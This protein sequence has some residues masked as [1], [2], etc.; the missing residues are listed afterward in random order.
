MLFKI[1]FFF[2]LLLLFFNCFIF[3]Q[4]H[5]FLEELRKEYRAIY[6]SNTF[7]EHI[8]ERTFLYAFERE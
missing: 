6:L 5:Q 1:Y 8:F 3:V 2:S 7:S 4:L